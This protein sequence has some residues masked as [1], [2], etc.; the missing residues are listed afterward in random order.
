MTTA[1]VQALVPVPQQRE[2]LQHSRARQTQGMLF[3]LR[4]GAWSYGMTRQRWSWRC[5]C[6][7]TLL[8]W[9]NAVPHAA[10]GE[11]N[12]RPSAQHDMREVDP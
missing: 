7:R 2:I 11:S 10:H 6:E 12:A 9:R 3:T 5:L 4:H 1:S 8:L